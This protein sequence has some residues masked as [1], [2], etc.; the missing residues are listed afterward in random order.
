MFS[1]VHDRWY[2]DTFTLSWVPLVYGSDCTCS[3]GYP[4]CCIAYR[5]FNRQCVY[6]FWITHLPFTNLPMGGLFSPNLLGVFILESMKLQKSWR[7]WPNRRR[8]WCGWRKGELIQMRWGFSL[9]E[10]FQPRPPE[11]SG[12]PDI[13][14]YIYIQLGCDLHSEITDTK[15]VDKCSK[16]GVLTLE[17]SL[18]CTSKLSSL[19]RVFSDFDNEECLRSVWSIEQKQIIVASSVAPAKNKMFS[20]CSLNIKLFFFSAPCTTVLFEV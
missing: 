7:M 11:I 10:E 6:H 4:S 15:S 3:K 2:L 9:S 19:G 5:F 14:I 13:Y 16:S 20:L 12:A 1:S 8:Y 18:H 17:A